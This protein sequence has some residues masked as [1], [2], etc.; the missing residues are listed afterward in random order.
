MGDSSESS[1]GAPPVSPRSPPGSL[2]FYGKRTQMV[3]VQALEREIG[4]LQDELKSVDGFQ[5]A[6]AYCKEVD[7]FVGAT[8]DPLVIMYM[9]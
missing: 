4:L 8:Q 1:F 5:P 6:S 2:D 9:P 7:D 3:K